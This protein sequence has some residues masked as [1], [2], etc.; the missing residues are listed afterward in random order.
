MLEWILTGLS[1]VASVI[2]IGRSLSENQS[3]YKLQSR[4]L[5]VE[6][7]VRR[8]RSTVSSLDSN[9]GVPESVL[10]A[11]N[12]LMEDLS[13]DTK[14]TYYLDI[15]KA[16]EGIWRVIRKRKP[17]ILRDPK[18]EYAFFAAEF[19]PVKIDVTVKVPSETETGGIKLNYSHAYKKLLPPLHGN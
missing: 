15:Q 6:A 1:T 7:S 5:N 19:I 10:H 2:N 13:R 3:D 9:E 8:L 12:E 11:Y 18:G 17:T 14:F 4:F 16:P